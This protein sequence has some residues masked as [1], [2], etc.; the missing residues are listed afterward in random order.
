[1]KKLYIV[2]ELF[3]PNKTST[4]YIMTELANHLAAYYHVSVVTTD[5]KYD[6]NIADNIDNAQY[7]VSR[8]KVGKVDKNSFFSRIKG[9]VGSSILLAF[10]LFKNIKKE[11]KALVVTNPFLIIFFVALIR[12]IKK[13]EYTLLVHDVF[14][15]NTIPAG[16]KNKNTI[17]YKLLKIV[18][19]WS[20]RKADKVIVL[21]EDM[22]ELLLLKGVSNTSIDVITN[23]FDDDVKNEEIDKEEYLGIPNIE[24][25]IIVGFAGNVG[26]VQGLDKFIE[27][28]N[29][30]GNNKLVL[31]IVGDGAMLEELTENNK[32]NDNI[33]FLGS[34][35]RS[36]QSLFLNSFDIALV[37]LENGMYG[38]GVPSKSYN[39]LRVGK[40]ILYIGDRN[41]EID[42][43]I[44]KYEC[45]WSIDWKDEEKI[46][47]LLKDLKSSHLE[48]YKEKNQ[49]LALS[50]YNSTTIKNQFLIVLNK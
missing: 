9:A 35:R 33:Y 23:W 32:A 2:S 42:L 21:G 39:I 50:M 3:Y 49:E 15:E 8:K 48:G 7:T 44:N 30:V 46:I 36:D 11:D 25:K 20:Y 27:C 40:P 26:R 14:P 41:S 24:G 16:L 19:D 6:G 29:K 5:I 4:A 13:F 45:G 22:K 17:S 37:T 28:F 1:M 10:D 47:A 18:F 43:M 12:L 34:K 31:V 38:L